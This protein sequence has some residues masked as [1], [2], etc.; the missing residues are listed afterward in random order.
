MNVSKPIIV[1]ET[2]LAMVEVRE[3]LTKIKKRDE[4][5]NFRANK[6][7][8]YLTEFAKLKPKEFEEIKQKLQALDVP[9]V[10]EQ[11]ILKLIDLLPKTVEEARTILGSYNLTVSAENLKK[12]IEI[13]SA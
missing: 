11:H 3:L 4:E 1:E 6:T 2:P 9:R 10:K 7:Y 8:E 13:T 12:I 5:L